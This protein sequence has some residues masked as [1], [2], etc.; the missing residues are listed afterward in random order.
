MVIQGTDGSVEFRFFRPDAREVYL[1]GDFNNWGRT[2]LRMERDA[3]GWW[4]L[5]ATLPPGFYQFQY[6]ADGQWYP[7]YAAF[8]LERGPFGWNSVVKVSPA[9]E[10]VEVVPA[11]ERPERQAA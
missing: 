8:G 6:I 7:D 11:E 2:D 3:Q 4:R 1:A 5:E 9:V 10:P